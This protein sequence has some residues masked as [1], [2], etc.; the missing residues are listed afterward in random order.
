[1]HKRGVVG[2]PN[3]AIFTEVDNNAVEFK[4]AIYY[5]NRHED[6]VYKLASLDIIGEFHGRHI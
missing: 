5:M 1:M 3:V 2:G 6:Y 4:L